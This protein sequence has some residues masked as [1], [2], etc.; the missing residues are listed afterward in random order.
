MD[1][2]S[3]E[4]Y[5]Q[6]FTNRSWVFHPHSRWYHLTSISIYL[7]STE[8][9]ANPQHSLACIQRHW[10]SKY[11]YR[12]PSPEI[13]K[14]RHR[15]TNFL[16]PHPSSFYQTGM[17]ADY[18]NS[19]PPPSR[20]NQATMMISSRTANWRRPGCRTL[21]RS[22]CS[23]PAEGTPPSAHRSSP[24]PNFPAPLWLPTAARPSPAISSWSRS[25]PSVA[26]GH[27][28]SWFCTGPCP[29]W[30]CRR[31]QFAPYCRSGCPIADRPPRSCDWGSPMEL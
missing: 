17:S 1:F 13:Q 30:T 26:P 6:E 15:K 5:F 8:L 25:G 11:A 27:S 31:A 7:Q 18:S 12:Q 3:L 21:P 16:S 24:A 9:T 10:W 23:C 4:F 29:G 28:S 22:R 19:L 2:E 20:R 14:R